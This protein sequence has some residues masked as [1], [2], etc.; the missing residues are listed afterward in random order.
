MAPSFPCRPGQSDRPAGAFAFLAAAAEPGATA[1]VRNLIVAGPRQRVESLRNLRQPVR[2]PAFHQ[3]RDGI[4]RSAP[5]RSVEHCKI[6]EE[7]GRAFHI[8]AVQAVQGT[9]QPLDSPIPSPPARS[10]P[11]TRFKRCFNGE[12]GEC[13]LN[14]LYLARRRAVDGPSHRGGSRPAALRKPRVLSRHFGRPRP[15][16]LQREDFRPPGRPKNQR[17]TNQPQPAPLRGRRH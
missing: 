8:A 12:G 17:Q 1:H 5:R 15:R 10:W 7:S 6:Q 16:R 3:R 2:R 14:G 4:G 13:V 11:A 9:G